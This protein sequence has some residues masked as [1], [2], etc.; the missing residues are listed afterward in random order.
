MG[1]NK[2]YFRLKLCSVPRALKSSLEAKA[3]SPGTSLDLAFEG[4]MPTFM[5]SLS[6]AQHLHAYYYLSAPCSIRAACVSEEQ[7]S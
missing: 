1:G 5:N 4:A 3:F 7:R 2:A 6:G